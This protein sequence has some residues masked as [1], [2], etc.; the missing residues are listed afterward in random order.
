MNDET[1]GVTAVVLAGGRGKRVG[2][3]KALLRIGEVYLLEIVLKNIRAIFDDVLLFVSSIDYDY[4]MSL[5]L[6]LLSCYCTDVIVD[7]ISN[8][9][10]LLGFIQG[11]MRSDNK[12]KFLLGCDM[13]FVNG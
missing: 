8:Q 13:P 12:L 9:G 3:N 1:S 6:S 10:P 7:P 4:L 5:H 11:M 2:Q